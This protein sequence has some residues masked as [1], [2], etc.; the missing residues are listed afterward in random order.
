MLGKLYC[1]YKKI[2]ATQDNLLKMIEIVFSYKLNKL[3]GR[4]FSTSDVAY[5]SCHYLYDYNTQAKY[6]EHT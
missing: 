5:T 1:Y 6:V 3:L 4:H 2:Q